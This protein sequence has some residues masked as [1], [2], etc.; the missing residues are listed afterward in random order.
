MAMS[1]ISS[2]RTGDPSREITAAVSVRGSTVA[3]AEPLVSGADGFVPQR[4]AVAQTSMIKIVWVNVGR[5]T[6]R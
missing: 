4:T 3:V 6:P 5:V 1:E 2:A